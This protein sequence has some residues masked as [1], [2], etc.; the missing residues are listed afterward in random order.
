MPRPKRPY[1]HFRYSLDF[2]RANKPPRLCNF[3]PGAPPSSAPSGPLGRHSLSFASVKKTARTRFGALLCVLGCGG[4]SGLLAESTG[5]T[6]SV[7]GNAGSVA[8][9]GSSG[10]LVTGGTSG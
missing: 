8:T 10:S 7:G 6:T 2:L 5:G 9:G 1:F 3:L 4:R